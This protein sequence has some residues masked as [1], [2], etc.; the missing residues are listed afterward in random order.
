MEMMTLLLRLRPGA[1]DDLENLL[2]AQ[3]NLFS[4]LYAKWLTPEEFGERFGI[5]LEEIDLAVGWLQS[6]G[7]DVQ[8]P[9]KGRGWINFT[10]TVGQVSA[11]FQTEIREYL[12]DGEFHYANA[13]ELRLPRWIADRSLGVAFTHNFHQRPLSNWSQGNPLHPLGSPQATYPSG[14][15]AL[16]PEDFAIIYNSEPVFAANNAGAGVTVAVA[17]QTEINLTDVRTFRQTFGLPAAD[18]VI[19]RNGPSPGNIG[20]KD[21]MESDLDVEWVGATAPGATVLFVISPK[22]SGGVVA[23]ALYVVENNSA[24]IL[25]YSYGSCEQK[26]AAQDLLLFS[27][28]WGQAAAQGISVLVSSGDFGVAACDSTL[29]AAGP[30]SVNGQ[31]STPYNTCVGGTE[32]LDTVNPAA[33]WSPMNNQFLASAL[34]YIPEAAWNEST[35][36]MP[37]AS[38][39]GPSAFWPKPAWQIAPGVPA[40]NFRDTPDVSLNASTRVGYLIE[41]GGSLQPIGGTSAATPSFAGI[42]ALTLRH[43]GFRQGNPAPYLYHLGANQ[44]AGQGPG[45]FHDITTGTNSVSGLTGFDCTSGYDLVT[46]LGS[47]NAAALVANW[48]RQSVPSGE[49]AYYPGNPSV[50]QTVIF[51]DESS[52]PPTGWLWNFGDPAS[53]TAN[54]STLQTPT[55]VFGAPGMYSVSL[56]AA[57]TVGSSRV[58]ATLVVTEPAPPVAGFNFS[59]SNPKAGQTV[60]FT[61]VSTGSP[62]SWSWNFGDPA[63]GSAN[64]STDQNPTHT[65]ATKGMYTVT[66]TASNAGGSSQASFAVVVAAATQGCSHCAIVVPFRTPR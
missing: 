37:S 62:T 49:F 4:P 46:G 1:G 44:Y 29:P 58:V 54:T 47:I 17:G 53:G 38:G 59:P 28:I 57:N 50:N 66:L 10:G 2:A 22:S 16:S 19:V 9:A 31:C 51:F 55:H 52:G 40:D 45:V 14:A 36:T 42:M 20:G 43:L 34:S 56:T 13:S 6:Q 3:Q 61:D 11:A 24:D 25:S 7:F 33:Y 48:P 39:G 63:S 5:S 60:S 8:P 65:F 12:V 41:S 21:E 18:P 23:S 32:F 27:V 35:S 26:S 64:T 15:H 30:Q